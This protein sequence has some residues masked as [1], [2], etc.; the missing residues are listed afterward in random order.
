[1]VKARIR[2]SCSACAPVHGHAGKEHGGR[3]PARE[4]VLVKSAPLAEYTG[5][6]EA[7]KEMLDLSKL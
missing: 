4:G 5:P 7:T 6:L 1:M 2:N 3:L